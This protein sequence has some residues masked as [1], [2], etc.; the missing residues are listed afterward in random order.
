ML[1]IKSRDVCDLKDIHDVLRVSKLLANDE[2][3][4]VDEVHDYILYNQEKVLLILDGYDEYFCTGEQSPVRDI[5]EGTL[6]RDCRVIMAIESKQE[7]KR[8]LTK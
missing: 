8:K 6:L 4:P 2:V 7:S 3:V 5:W 1:L